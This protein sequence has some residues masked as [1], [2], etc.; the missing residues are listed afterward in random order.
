[1]A[2]G[3][4]R[5][6]SKR[7]HKQWCLGQDG[8][9]KAGRGKSSSRSGQGRGW[10]PGDTQIPR[11][12]IFPSKPWGIS[13]MSVSCTLGAGTC[14][15]TPHWVGREPAYGVRGSF[16]E[17]E[18][19]LSPGCGSQCSHQGAPPY[20]VLLFPNGNSWETCVL[21]RSPVKISRD[22]AWH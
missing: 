20:P 8:E 6:W 10:G 7:R 22:K 14:S 16:Q 2:V 19:D 5:G 1:M 13:L 21:G 9:E 11:A 15:P 18:A 12:V 3:R 17:R 4:P